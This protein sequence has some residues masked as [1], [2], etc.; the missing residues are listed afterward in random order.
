MLKVYLGDLGLFTYL[1]T[2]PSNLAVKICTTQ[3][4]TANSPTLNTLWATSYW[5]FR[6]TLPESVTKMC[7][8]VY[9]YI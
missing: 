8:R 6:Q 2:E 5:P 9:I 4:L 1:P 7:M 3:R